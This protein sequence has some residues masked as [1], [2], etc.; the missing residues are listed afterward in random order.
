MNAQIKTVRWFSA[1][2]IFMP[3]LRKSLN[4]RKIGKIAPLRVVGKPENIAP[5]AGIDTKTLYPNL[6]H[7][8]ARMRLRFYGSDFVRLQRRERIL[9]Y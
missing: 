4:R 3:K 6:S 1:T 7:F 5:A 9:L 8:P 2:A